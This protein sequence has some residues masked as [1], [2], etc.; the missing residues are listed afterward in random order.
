MSL[1]RKVLFAVVTLLLVAAGTEG[2][3]RVVWHRLAKR[4]FEQT[5]R[6]GQEVLG[7]PSTMNF[8]TIPSGMYGYTLKPNFSAG[9]HF[10]NAAGFA[11]RETV[12]VER[13]AGKLRVAAMGESTTEGHHVDKACY[14]TYLRNLFGNLCHGYSGVEVINGGVSGWLSDQVALR[15]EN[16]MAAYRPDLVVLYVGWNDFQG[17][18]PYG[19]V[20][21]QSIF[22]IYYSGGKFHELARAH[23]KSL[24]LLSAFYQKH[25]QGASQPHLSSASSRPAAAAIYH[26]YLKNLDRIVAA[27][28]QANPRVKIFLCTLVARW[29]Q[30]DET[31]FVKVPSGRTSG[32]R[33]TA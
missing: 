22:D 14:P 12:P 1:C 19:E 31:E 25:H 26:F 9:D 13:V 16:Q 28:R 24:A 3:A 8:M 21:S 7:D 27:Y 23:C 15:A 17:Y 20:L 2:L 18:D 11:Q 6:R 30:V 5:R 10:I 32:C 4:A 29:P 33:I